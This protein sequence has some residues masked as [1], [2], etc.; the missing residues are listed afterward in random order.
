MSNP[1]I[2]LREGTIDD[3]P[4]L[5][6]FIRGM[7]EFEKLEATVTEELLRASL[8]SPEPAARVLM[9][10]LDGKPVG[11][12]TYFFSFS[13]MRGRRS[14]WL[15]D[16]FVTPEHRGQGIGRVFMAHLA[17]IAMQ[18]GCCRLE[19]I[20]LD[21]NEKAIEFYERLGASVLP[22]WRICRLTE[23]Q[24]PSVAGE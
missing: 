11:Y 12:A 5:L 17:G 23:D 2:E 18:H 22:D 9:V 1:R 21:W 4:A 24:L 8:F 19:W 16:L 20:V 15:E 10:E 6:S 7:A 3:V 14:M 13:T